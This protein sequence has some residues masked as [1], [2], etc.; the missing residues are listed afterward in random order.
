MTVEAANIL[1]RP[2]LS[3]EVSEDT[4]SMACADLLALRNVKRAKPRGKNLDKLKII[5]RTL[6]RGTRQRLRR[7]LSPCTPYP[8]PLP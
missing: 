7:G 1:R 4:A 2:A 6:G 3:G 5:A 8:H